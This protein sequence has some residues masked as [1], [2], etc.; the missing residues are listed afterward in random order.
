[1]RLR[2]KTPKPTSADK[3]NGYYNKFFQKALHILIR[4]KS[5]PQVIRIKKIR[6]RRSSTNVN[7]ESENSDSIKSSTTSSKKYHFRPRK[8][9]KRKKKQSNS[10]KPDDTS[11]DEDADY[12]CHKKPV[13]QSTRNKKKKPL[14]KLSIKRTRIHHTIMQPKSEEVSEPGNRIR[15]KM[16][17]RAQRDISTFIINIYDRLIEEQK[18]AEEVKRNSLFQELQ[19]ELNGKIQ[20]LLY[21][22]SHFVYFLNTDD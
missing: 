3:L 4:R 18:S 6:S 20:S 17:R 11:N 7:S 13:V 14:P 10:P 8:S 9:K 21:F 19:E 12:H 16:K 2:S 22:I 5:K 15:H 1:M